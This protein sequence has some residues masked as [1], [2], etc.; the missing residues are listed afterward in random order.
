LIYD[1]FRFPFTG[2]WPEFSSEGRGLLNLH[3]GFHPT[4]PHLDC[5]LAVAVLGPV[6]AVGHQLDYCRVHRVD[7]DLET[8]QQS[9]PLATCC[10]TRAGGLKMLKHR[11]EEPLGEKRVAF[12]VRVRER[13]ARRGSDA[14]TRQHR[15]L[16]PQPVAHVIEADGV[17]KLG[18]EHR[19]QMARHAEGSRF[20]IHAG[21]SGMATN[22]VQRNEVENLL[23]DDYV[24]AGWCLFF[25]PCQ[26]AG[27][28][29]QRQPTFFL[30]Y[31]FLWD[32]CEVK[33]PLAKKIWHAAKWAVH[34]EKKVEEFL[35]P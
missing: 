25:H 12:L 16:E 33:E 17:R 13:V 26:V 35:N 18:E 32:G 20:G 1:E 9:A 34:D 11:P 29:E 24:A 22:Q 8:S 7:F 2:Y 31:K 3:A 15:C 6:H 28:S 5:R 23:K 14:E 30:N 27:F 10:E 4:N 19:G 21:F